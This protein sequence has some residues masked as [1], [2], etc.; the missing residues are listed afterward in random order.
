MNLK[1]VFLA[2]ICFCLSLE[3]FTQTKTIKL[4][5]DIEDK[6]LQMPLTGACI[7]IMDVDSTVVVDSASILLV[8]NSFD[9]LE[10]V[11]FHATVKAEKRN[12]L[13]R[14]S[15]SGYEDMWQAISVLYPDIVSEVTVP[16][17]KMSKIKEVNMEELV[18]TA[19][20]IKMF[21]KG[22]TLVYNA[23]AFNLPNGSMLDDLIK[24]M[25]GVTINENGQIFVN[26]RMVD[27]L[28]LGARSFMGGT[29]RY[30][31][32]ICRIIQ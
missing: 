5:G 17:F 29:S 18:V 1:N 3:A 12:Y 11:I 9:K 30:L 24:Q 8:N 23:D 14:A 4:V 19:T 21:Y 32:I 26:G 10:K 13:I 31:W 20:K 25:P 2:L 15:R 22:D 7:T 27:E 6:Y 16:T 28:L